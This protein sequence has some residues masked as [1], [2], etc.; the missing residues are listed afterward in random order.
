M[1][2]EESELKKIDETESSRT[3]AILQQGMAEMPLNNEI[4]EAVA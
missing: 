3:L 1:G 4:P 2:A